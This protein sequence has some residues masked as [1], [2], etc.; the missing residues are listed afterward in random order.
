MK[1]I[2]L[3][4]LTIIVISVLVTIREA[5]NIEKDYKELQDKKDERK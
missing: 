2:A 4:L 3:I 5:Y 1:I